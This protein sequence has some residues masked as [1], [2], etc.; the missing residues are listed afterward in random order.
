MRF[1][2]PAFLLGALAAAVPIVL[3]LLRREP[4]PRVRFPAV[5]LLRAAPVE[6]ASKRSVRERFLLALRVSALVLLAVAFAR[7]FVASSAGPAGATV[8]LLDTSSSLSAPGVF[9]RARALARGAVRRAAPSDLVGLVTFADAPTF[10][11]RPSADR[12]LAIAAIDAATAGFGATRYRGAFAAGVQ[13]LDGRRGTLVVVTDLQEGGWDL[14]DRAP[15]PASTR[16]E[17][18]D[19]GGIRSNLAVTALRTD[20]G[21][22]TATVGNSG[23]AARE[24]R[25]HLDLDGARA[26]D[27]QAVVGPQTSVDVSFPIDPAA[28]TGSFSVDDPEGIA[29]DNTRYIVLHDTNRPAVFVVTSTGD[30]EQ[31]GFYVHQAIAAGSVFTP[32]GMTPRRLSTLGR[33]QLS[34]AAAVLLLST[35]GLERRGREALAEYV[36]GGGGLLIAA[37]PAVDGEMV[38]DLLGG[39]RPLRMTSAPDAGSP[40]RSLVVSDR[41]HPVFRPFGMN[42]AALG[43][44]K[45]RKVARVDRAGCQT[46]AR[47]TGGEPAVLDCGEEKGRVMVIASDLDNRW[48]DFPVHASFIAFLDET[49]AYLRGGRLL[50]AEF[51][52]GDV[53]GGVAPKPGIVVLPAT[54]AA[55]AGRRLA[56]NVDPRESDV[57]RLT[58]AEF[59]NA[60]TRLKE[61]GGPPSRTADLAQ[62]DRQHLWAYVLGMT[63]V[64][65]AVE[66]LVASRTA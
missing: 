22:I 65:L 60:V 46:I 64:V 19:V 58:A 6:A 16:V 66:G 3:H 56:V 10:A 45:F 12:A 31:D 20:G 28:M 9:A 24:V 39:E 34:A 27:A 26:A 14:G 15:V 18:L 42:G 1:L 38:G 25:A 47:F 23:D 43:L 33:P 37:G 63:L 11:A 36:G 30:F 51:G 40:A 29:A 4:E 32:V 50:P 54:A 49:L 21:V 59:Q 2:S 13:A 35:Q 7:P 55:P 62:Q 52:V 41:R 53:T 5:R 44:A 57:T 48:N 8:V 61:E 17:V